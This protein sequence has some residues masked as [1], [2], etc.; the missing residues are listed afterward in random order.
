MSLDA[1]RRRRRHNQNGAALYRWRRIK[2]R[3]EAAVVMVVL[4]VLAVA[5]CILFA[6]I[7]LFL[8]GL[9]LVVMCCIAF[10]LTG[11]LALKAMREMTT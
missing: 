8:L 6:P 10:W 4:V 2:G 7:L 3:A 9:A 11:V 1:A 5:G